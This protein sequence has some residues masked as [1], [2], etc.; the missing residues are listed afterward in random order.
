MNMNKFMPV[1]SIAILFVA[2]IVCT[3]GFSA[4]NDNDSDF[5]LPPLKTKTEMKIKQDYLKSYIRPICPDAAIDSITI[6]KY[7]GTYG[8]C[9]AVLMSGGGLGYS[10]ALETEVVGGVTIQ[11]FSSNKMLIWED[12][13]FGK[14]G[15]FY[16]LQE[17]YN[18]GLLTK[19]NL[20]KIS[21]ISFKNY[22]YH[23]SSVF[24]W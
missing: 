2:A 15:K 18:K 13:N 20:R 3:A 14:E 6:E 24:V 12:G 11:Y 21:D 1:L 22:N 4:Q 16:S 17:A 19:G 7:Y 10:L 8:G 23:E 9:V 5:P